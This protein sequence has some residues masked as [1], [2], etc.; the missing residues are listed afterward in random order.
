MSI[1]DI[2]WD[3]QREA[4]ERSTERRK[5]MLA[6]EPGS[7]KTLMAMATLQELGAFEEGVSLIC[8]P[9][10]PA[11]LTWAPHFATHAP[12]VPLVNCYSGSGAQKAARIRSLIPGSIVLANHDAL[13]VAK[14]GKETVPGLTSLPFRHV[15]IDEA[16][17][18]IPT[19]T[20]NLSEMTQFWR[21]FARIRSQLE[22]DSLILLMSGTPDRGKLHNRYGYLKALWPTA[23]R[24]FWAWA[25][26]NF[27]VESQ[28]IRRFDPRMGRTISRQ[29]P[30]IGSIRE[31]AK[32]R[33]LGMDSIYV[34]RRTKDE[35]RAGR[36]RK[37]S[38]PIMLQL[39][40][41]QVKALDEYDR[42]VWEREVP[43]TPATWAIRSRQLAGIGQWSLPDDG[44]QHATPVENAASAKFDWIVAWMRTRGYFDEDYVIDPE[45]PSKVVISFAFTES[46]RWVERHLKAAGIQCEIG[47]LTGGQAS[48]NL[49]VKERFQDFASPMRVVLLQQAT[50][51]GIDLDAADDLIH[52]DIPYDPDLT[53][54]VEDRIDRLSR[55]HQTTIWWLIARGT[56]DAAIALE[57]QDRFESTRE[58]L[59]GA[60]G[61]EYQ[62]RMLGKIERGARHA[63]DAA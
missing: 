51:R 7:G 57:N 61:L 40:E 62:R 24:D 4:V 34:I 11:R 37:L 44:P 50:G 46:L 3:V 52:F 55:D 32:P 43:D 28:E 14:T 36:P 41:Q 59:D 23:H 10:D 45:R 12:E 19:A 63:G 56:I 8:V 20:D 35:I 38:V 5:I 42:R 60:R 33:W 15:V 26:D 49:R 21:G 16:H 9:K 47:A 30:V 31:S 53:Q 1:T 29:V 18:V 48:E 25:R 22:L 27:A 13:G 17:E 58:L 39:E 2:L 54:Q 6:D